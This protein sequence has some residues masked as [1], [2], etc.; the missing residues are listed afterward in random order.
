MCQLTEAI[1]CYLEIALAIGTNAEE[2][3]MVVQ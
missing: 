3:H 2:K 1:Q